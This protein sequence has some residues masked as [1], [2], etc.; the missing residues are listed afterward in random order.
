MKATARQSSS[1]APSRI[2][3]RIKHPQ[4][5]T[6]EIT[7][8]LAMTPEHTL[9][10]GRSA[11]ASGS[12]RLHAESYWIAPVQPPGLDDPWTL[13]DTDDETKRKLSAAGSGPSPVHVLG[14]ESL[15]SMTLRQLQPHQDFFQRVLEEGGSSTLLISVDASGSLTIPPM[16]ARM[17]AQTGLSLE[18]D[19]SDS[20]E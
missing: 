1:A 15:L 6:T 11:S 2:H 9:E 17:L 4:L 18:L 7:R 20:V 14:N 19:W 8:V 3:L 12:E 10:A 16:L 13:G 5:D